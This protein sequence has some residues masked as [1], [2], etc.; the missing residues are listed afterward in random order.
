MSLGK[1]NQIKKNVK[2]FQKRFDNESVIGYIKEE[3]QDLYKNEPNNYASFIRR[4][5]QKEVEILEAET[6]AQITGQ[7]IEI[8]TQLIDRSSPGASGAGGGS[9]Y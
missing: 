1:F 3:F 4:E 8:E 9:S 6:Q 5:N 7:E 2:Y